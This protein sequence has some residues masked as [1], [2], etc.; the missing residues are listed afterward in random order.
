FTLGDHPYG[1]SG[2]AAVG[3]FKGLSTFSQNVHAQNSDSLSQA[4]ASKALFGIDKEMYLGIILQNA[5]NPK[6]RYDPS[7][8]QK[9]SAFFASVD[10]TPDAPGVN[11]LVSSPDSP[12]LS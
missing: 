11:E 10:P 3:P 2:F 4:D 12:K 7:T 9:P 6:Y 5:A 8:G 1:W